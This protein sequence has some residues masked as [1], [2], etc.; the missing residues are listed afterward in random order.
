MYFLFGPSPG[1]GSPGVGVAAT[2]FACT[3]GSGV[4]RCLSLSG[5]CSLAEGG[6]TPPGPV[7]GG[8]AGGGGGR[9]GRV[10]IHPPTPP[11]PPPPAPCSPEGGGTS[12]GGGAPSSSPLV[13]L[14]APP[15]PAGCAGVMEISE[16]STSSW[17]SS[18]TSWVRGARGPAGLVG[19]RS[20]FL[21]RRRTLLPWTRK[22]GSPALYTRSVPLRV[23]SWTIVWFTTRRT[24]WGPVHFT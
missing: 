14:L 5:S 19:V 6:S 22:C 1:T 11:P 7:R 24:T 12:C 17:S 10:G 15:L 23:P 13:A 4:T 8:R 2:L 21:R 18:R 16:P 20:S 9:R 3:G